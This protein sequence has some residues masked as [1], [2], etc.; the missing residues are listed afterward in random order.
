[1]HA[2]AAPP[3]GRRTLDTDR[4]AAFSDG[5]FAIAA[6][7]LVLDLAVKP[8][9]TPL[10]QVVHAW[11]SYLG[12]VVS[13]LTIGAAWLAHSAMTDRLQRSNVNL[14]RLNLL[15]LLVVAFLPFPT[16]LMTDA[17]HTDDGET[18]AVTVYGVT[19]LCIRLLGSCLNAYA[20]RE[21][22]YAPREGDGEAQ[23]TGQGL[24]FV[25]IGY[26]TAILIGLISPE[27]AAALYFG[28]AV[29]L[30]L[31]IAEFANL[32]RRA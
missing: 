8:P 14:L 19:L 15:F 10:E 26:V 3:R 13:F 25:V 12:Y 7:L 32:L 11:P 17:L 29:Y 1:M 6:T 9:G 27:A 4:L 5:V 18:V 28:L 24:L 16:R 20:R 22:L 23:D 21:H 2:K 31:P 30:V